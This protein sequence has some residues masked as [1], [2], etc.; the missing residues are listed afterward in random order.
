[1]S[2][3]KL[4]LCFDIYLLCYSGECP[5]EIPVVYRF[6]QKVLAAADEYDAL[7][8]DDSLDAA[9][10]E[11]RAGEITVDGATFEELALTMTYVASN[12]DPA[13]SVQPLC[14]SG[15]NIEVILNNLI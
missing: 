10:R 12:A 7:M 14:D 4:V 3:I 2:V 1:M 5:F 6:L 13:V 11:R 8:R 9:E 15:E